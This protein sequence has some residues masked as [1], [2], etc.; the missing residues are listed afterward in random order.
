MLRN[1]SIRM[2]AFAGL[3][4]QKVPGTDDVAE[5]SNKAPHEGRDSDISDVLALWKQQFVD[6]LT[7]LHLCFARVIILPL[8]YFICF[9]VRAIYQCNYGE[10][11]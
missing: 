5:P 6:A 7:V 2:I 4:Y 10:Q 1:F 3:E 8:F 9:F 11:L